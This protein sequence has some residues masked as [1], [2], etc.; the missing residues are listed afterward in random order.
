MP[1]IKEVKKSPKRGIINKGFGRTTLFS[2]RDLVEIRIKIRKT[3]I[4]KRTV[5]PKPKISVK[6]GTTVRGKR[7]VTNPKA[8]SIILSNFAFI[9]FSLI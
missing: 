6:K 8:I 9:I 4:P 3:E 7:K 1:E 5:L 2:K